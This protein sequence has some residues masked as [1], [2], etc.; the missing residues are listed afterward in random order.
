MGN[1]DTF[2]YNSANPSRIILIFELDRD[3]GET[4]LWTK[5]LSQSDDPLKSYRVHFL[6]TQK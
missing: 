6:S 3:I 5:T 4:M 1:N 2:C